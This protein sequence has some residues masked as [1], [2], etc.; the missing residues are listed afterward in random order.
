LSIF[1]TKKKAAE[2]EAARIRKAA[3]EARKV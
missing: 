3:E 2:E 1:S